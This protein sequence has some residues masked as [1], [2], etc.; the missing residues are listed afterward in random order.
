MF[1]AKEEW[2]FIL[3]IFSRRPPK[4]FFVDGVRKRP[5][6][7]RIMQKKAHSTGDG[8]AHRYEPRFQRS[9]DHSPPI[10]CIFSS[11]WSQPLYYG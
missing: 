8:M 11:G 3:A 1:M 4:A 9:R 2:N 5:T 7:R 10:F 6:G